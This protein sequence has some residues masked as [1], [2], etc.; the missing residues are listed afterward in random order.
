MSLSF[1]EGVRT[2][3]ED[4]DASDVD[5]DAPTGGAGD[6]EGAGGGDAA[7][8]AGAGVLR[9]DALCAEGGDCACG[10]AGAASGSV[11]AGVPDTDGV[12]AGGV[13]PPLSSRSISAFSSSVII[14]DATE[15]I[16][17]MSE[18]SPIFGSLSLLV[19]TKESAT[20]VVVESF[21]TKDIGEEACCVLHAYAALLVH[22][23]IDQGM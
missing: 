23:N 14:A 3:P 10:C 19:G 21:A 8:P 18:I 13:A 16:S 9:F 7:V 4:G 22:L 20:H 2:G 12:C 15:V 17:F 5:E 6:V 1:S 11:A